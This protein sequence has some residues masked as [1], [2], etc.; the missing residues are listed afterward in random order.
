MY[1]ITIGHPNS[2]K[3]VNNAEPIKERRGGREI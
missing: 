2:G 3:K 1:S